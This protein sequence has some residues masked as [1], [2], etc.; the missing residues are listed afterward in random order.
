MADRKMKLAWFIPLGFFVEIF[1]SLIGATGPV[2]NP[3][4]LNYGLEKEKMIATKTI[5]S[6]LIDLVQISSYTILGS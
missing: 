3:F 1:S 4:Y 5:N 2:L 6:F